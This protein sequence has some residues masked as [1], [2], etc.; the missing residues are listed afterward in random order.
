MA[1]EETEG[2]TVYAPDDREAAREEFDKFKKA[3]ETSLKGP[4]G[5][6][7][8]SRIGTRVR[9]LENAVKNME[10]LAQNQD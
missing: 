6:E 4:S 2:N 9:E 7:I 5:A 1:M 10:E 3:Y 8:E